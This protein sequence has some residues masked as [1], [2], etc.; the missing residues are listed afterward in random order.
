M[1]RPESNV[2]EQGYIVVKKGKSYND[3]VLEPNNGDSGINM[4]RIQQLRLELEPVLENA[5]TKVAILIKEFSFLT[6]AGRD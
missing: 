4:D 1:L 3:I 2:R 5:Q 6:Q